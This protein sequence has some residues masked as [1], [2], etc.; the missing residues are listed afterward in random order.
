[1]ALTSRKDTYKRR[2][3]ANQV[4]RRYKAI[5][6]SHGVETSRAKARKKGT[7]TCGERQ[8]QVEKLGIK[9][10][11][12]IL[13]PKKKGKL[14]LVKAV[15]ADWHLLLEGFDLPVSPLGLDDSRVFREA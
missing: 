13:F 11:M 7:C 10:G 8:S 9:P 1:M 3:R 2:T 15:T 5:L 14:Y 6:H 12:K 4:S